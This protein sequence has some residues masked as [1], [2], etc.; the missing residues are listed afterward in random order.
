[1]REAIARLARRMNLIVGRGKIKQSDD[2]QNI[3]RLQVAL[4]ALETMDN[5]PRAVEFGFAS[6][7]P[8]NCSAVVLFV[9][10]DRSN[11][12]AIATHDLPS[13]FK[14]AAKGE[15]AVFD[16]NGTNG[17]AGKWIWLKKGAGIEIEANGEPVVIKDAL[18][19]TAS[20]KAGGTMPVT[21]NTNGGD[22]TLNMNGGKV[23][24]VDPGQVVLSDQNGQKAV[25]R[26]GDAVV[27]GQ[28]VASQAAV[29][30]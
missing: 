22:I 24:I 17:A 26:H 4:S 14:L 16:G 23:K 19:I 2:S 15:S 18:S 25:A 3:Q 27:A 13:R 28:V 8:D 11:A 29:V 12:V 1:M 5:I 20:N 21:L 9:N 30:A 7:P 6:W 10:G